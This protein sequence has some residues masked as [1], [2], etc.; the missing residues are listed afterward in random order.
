MI[1]LSASLI[2]DN[3]GKY[4]L[5]QAPSLELDTYILQQYYEIALLLCLFFLKQK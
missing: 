4:L 3:K 5:C 1:Y 2:L